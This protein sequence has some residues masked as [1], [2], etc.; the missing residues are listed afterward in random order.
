MRLANP[1]RERKARLP[2][3]WAACCRR[4]RRTIN[5]LLA[6]IVLGTDKQRGRIPEGYSTHF[7]PPSFELAFRTLR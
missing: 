3:Y 4:S 5:R 2:F 1:K 7:H 6:K